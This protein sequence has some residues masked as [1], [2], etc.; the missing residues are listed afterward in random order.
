LFWCPPDNDLHAQPVQRELL[1]IRARSHSGIPVAVE[2]GV[3]LGI[4]GL[5]LRSAVIARRRRRLRILATIAALSMAGFMA[6]VAYEIWPHRAEVIADLSSKFASPA[7]ADSMPVAAIEPE[8]PVYRHSIVAGGAY[9]RHEVADAMRKD[10]VVAAHYQDVDVDSVRATTVDAAR[11]VFVSYRVGD[12]VYWTKNRVQLS[13]GE[14]VLT[15]GD[16]EIR[17]RCGNLLSD[18]AQQPVAADEPPLAALD[19]EEPE[20]GSS[21]IAGARGPEGGL[22]HLPFLAGPNGASSAA[23]GVDATPGAPVTGAPG[24]IGGGVGGSPFFD[25]STGTNGTSL[26]A[27][28]GGTERGNNPNGGGPNG[29]GPNGGGPNGGGPNGGGPNGGDPNGGDDELPPIFI[30][31]T[32]T[33]EVFTTTGGTETTTGTLTT[34]TTGNIVNDTTGGDDTDGETHTVPEP[35]TLVLLTMGACG[36]AARA[37]RRR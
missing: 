10:D 21:T 6:A 20:T 19:Q 23:A 36:L 29:G 30:P 26:V 22:S 34:T 24:L 37:L 12:Q 28:L 4:H 11:A 25:S 15:D 17:A 35:G 8:R 33:G 5:P 18:T 9:S 27:P 2:P 1:R 31:P 32:T 7:P 14:T 3:K 16:T 13:P